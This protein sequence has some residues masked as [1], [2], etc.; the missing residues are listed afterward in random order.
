MTC[1]TAGQCLNCVKALESLSSPPLNLNNA[2]G[3]AVQI[4]LERE[5]ERER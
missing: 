5:R 3:Y 1:G 2:A 4:L